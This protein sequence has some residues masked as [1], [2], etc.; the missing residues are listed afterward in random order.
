MAKENK[1]DIV[2]FNILEENSLL[3][4]LEDNIK[5]TIIT[6]ENNEGEK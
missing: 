2:I 3:K 1:I 6:S 4:V 5:R